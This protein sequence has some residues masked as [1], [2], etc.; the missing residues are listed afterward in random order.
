[1]EKKKTEGEQG[2]RVQSHSHG[3]LADIDSVGSSALVGGEEVPGVA[4]LAVP[5]VGDAAVLA[6]AALLV[7][8]PLGPEGLVVV[9]VN[10]LAW[11]RVV[12][13]GFTLRTD[14]GRLD[15]IGKEKYNRQEKIW[16]EEKREK[17]RERRVIR[18]SDKK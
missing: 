5:H 13:E 7:R 4:V 16:S 3:H 9:V 11:E 8:L 18:E 14:E 15:T 17:R 6:G 12:A 10:G 1:M 2:E